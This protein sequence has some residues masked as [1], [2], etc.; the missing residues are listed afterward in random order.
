MEAYHEERADILSKNKIQI[1]KNTVKTPGFMVENHWHDAYEILLVREGYGEQQ[2]NGQKF[3]FS[4]NTVIVIRPGDIHA[5]V[6]TSPMGCEIDV[7]QF[8]PEYLGEREDLLS[9]LISSV[10]ETSSED[11]AELFDKIKNHIASKNA[12][13]E[14]MLSGAVFMLCG[15]LVRECRHATTVVKMTAFT[16]SVCQY[17]RENGDTRLEAVSRHFGYSPEH[18]SRKFH[19]ESGICYKHYCEKIK[20][21]QILKSLDE[22]RISLSQIAEQLA[23]SDTSSFVRAFKRIYGIPPGAYRRLKKQFN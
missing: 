12:D 18:F 17:L 21:R 20:I 4:K 22:E 14:L 16:Q 11:I 2:I 6:A 7:L 8:I 1:S 5:T 3:D 13:G 19:T 9:E 15:I 23:Y 10:S